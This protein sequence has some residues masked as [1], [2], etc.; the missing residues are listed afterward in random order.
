LFTAPAIRVLFL[1]LAAGEV[2]GWQQE[3]WRLRL[4]DTGSVQLQ[5]GVVA[6]CREA[7]LRCDRRADGKL[8]FQGGVEV[9]DASGRYRWLA[10]N[11]ALQQGSGALCHTGFGRVALRRADRFRARLSTSSFSLPG[12]AVICEQTQGRLF[13]ALLKYPDNRNR[14]FSGWNILLV[15]E[16]RWRDLKLRLAGLRALQDE[17]KCAVSLGSSWRNWLVELNGGDLQSWLLSRSWQWQPLRLSMRRWGLRHS[18]PGSW[19]FA[20]GSGQQAAGIVQEVEQRRG[21]WKWYSRLQ[22]WRLQDEEAPLVTHRAR[23]E[24]RLHKRFACCEFKM[25]QRLE[26]EE[27]CVASYLAVGLRVRY[28]NGYLS[29]SVTHR[30]S[31]RY[32]WQ[33]RMDQGNWSL[34]FRTALGTAGAAAGSGLGLPGTVQWSW[35]Q[36]GQLELRLRRRLTWSHYRCDLLFQYLLESE[37]VDYPEDDR[38]VAFINW[39]LQISSL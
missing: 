19:P 36:P 14:G 27:I 11:L 2:A 22:L 1:I 35:M 9:G 32:L 25:R 39:A 8:H 34:Q 30:G 26:R 29:G 37:Q 15:T 31:S 13:L 3:P 12:T 23:F 17:N 18:P 5:A 28:D 7:R 24:W 4:S 38:A 16:R 21:S 6:Q 10:G 20:T 33:L